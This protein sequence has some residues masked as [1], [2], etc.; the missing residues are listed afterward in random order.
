MLFTHLDH[1][2]GPDSNPNAILTLLPLSLSRQAVADLTNPEQHADPEL[3]VLGIAIIPKTSF[4]AGRKKKL[5]KVQ[6]R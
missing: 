3:T 1:S 6:R 5:G 4:A 2:T